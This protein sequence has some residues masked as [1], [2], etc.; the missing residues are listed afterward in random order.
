MGT[1]PLVFAFLHIISIILI[2]GRINCIGFTIMFTFCCQNV[3]EN[4]RQV[5]CAPYGL[6]DLRGYYGIRRNWHDFARHCFYKLGTCSCRL[7][8]T[9]PADLLRSLDTERNGRPFWLNLAL[10]EFQFHT[11]LGRNKRLPVPQF[12]H[13]FCRGSCN[14]CWETC[15]F[16]P[17]LSFHHIVL[18]PLFLYITTKNIVKWSLLSKEMLTHQYILI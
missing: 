18:L 13:Q 10:T 6:L 8:E 16:L 11:Q 3:W 14:F 1:P 4:T 17:Y 9:L 5:Q 12:G 2:W 15:V 7:C